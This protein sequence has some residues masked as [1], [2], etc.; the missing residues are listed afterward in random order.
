M[1]WQMPCRL[2]RWSFKQSFSISDFPFLLPLPF[3]HPDETP[4][5]VSSSDYMTSEEPLKKLRFNFNMAVGQS[6]LTVILPRLL[7]DHLRP[8]FPMSVTAIWNNLSMVDPFFQHHPWRYLV[9]QCHPRSRLPINHPHRVN[10][11]YSRPAGGRQQEH[12]CLL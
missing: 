3:S 2:N 1:R 11:R 10:P 7:P 8:S 5:F 4:S 12:P 9:P 6:L